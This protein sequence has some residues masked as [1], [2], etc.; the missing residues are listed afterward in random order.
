M[1]RTIVQADY[2][3]EKE[4]AVEKVAATAVIDEYDI[5][6][7]GNLIFCNINFHFTATTAIA[8]KAG[9]FKISG[10]PQCACAE[11]NTE[12]IGRTKNAELYLG[13]Y[14]NEGY[15]LMSAVAFNPVIGEK[16]TCQLIYGVK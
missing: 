2:L 4:V 13:S 7:L 8:A 10:I 9:W 14:V 15:T 11:Q 16:L 6:R 5:H 3:N 12:V 1:R